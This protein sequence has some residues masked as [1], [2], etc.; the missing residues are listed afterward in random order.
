M[1]AYS[2]VNMN[3]QS[4]LWLSVIESCKPIPIPPIA[5]FMLSVRE[6][7]CPSLFDPTFYK[8]T[9]GVLQYLTLLAAISQASR[10]CI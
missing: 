1:K 6:G 9:V 7:S 10:R 5:Y 3:M 4:L 8:S 2:G